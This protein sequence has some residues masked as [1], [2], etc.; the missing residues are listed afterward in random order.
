MSLKQY[1]PLIG[2]IPLL[3]SVFQPASATLPQP[4]PTAS[5]QY[6]QPEDFERALKDM[7]G[8]FHFYTGPMPGPT[9]PEAPLPEVPSLHGPATEPL[10][11]RKFSGPLHV[12]T[13]PA[14]IM[15][16]LALLAIRTAS[17]APDGSLWFS[18]EQRWSIR[19]MWYDR[20]H[21]VIDLV[22]G[23]P[24]A[25]GYAN[26][27]GAS[28]RFRKVAGMASSQDGS[29][30]L[31][32]SDSHSV[33]RMVPSNDSV[34]VAGIAGQWINPAPGLPKQ[35]YFFP[36]NLNDGWGWLDGSGIEA[37]LRNP[38]AVAVAPDGS[39][40]VAD[41]GNAA[42]R[43]ITQAANGYAITTVT[44]TPHDRSHT[45]G[46]REIARF[47][48]P[49]DLAFARDGSL[50][51]A[52]GYGHCIRRMTPDGRITTIAGMRDRIGYRDGSGKEASFKFPHKLV[53][54]S[55]EEA[56]IADQ[57]NHCI[58][59]VRLDGTVTT[60]AGHPSLRERQDG[61]AA[62]AGFGELEGITMAP[63]GSILVIDG[64]LRLI[65]KGS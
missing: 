18:D 27:A 53:L 19:R 8:K 6:Y 37:K 35:A 29:M 13:V 1:V 55:N 24:Q 34:F 25:H 64:K 2:L 41:P 30:W 14:A 54:I 59:S 51:I 26:G 33:R 9:A 10:W 11:G 12:T 23:H 40:W 42:I 63:D 20:D 49:T 48:A 22:A 62:T 39:I 45:D 16:E 7:A 5:S 57:G 43:R 21:Y 4:S 60:I 44:G 3:C 15:P 50:W 52:D 32:D 65:R 58:R 56:W 61:P 28:A 47:R 46:P 31:A 38:E 17:F 36:P